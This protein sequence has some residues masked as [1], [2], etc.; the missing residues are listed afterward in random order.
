[1]QTRLEREN[2]GRGRGVLLARGHAGTTMLS[3][4]M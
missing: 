3:W 1:V 4:G 2:D